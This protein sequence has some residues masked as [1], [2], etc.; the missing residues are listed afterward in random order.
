MVR[1]LSCKGPD[2]SMEVFLPQAVVSDAVSMQKTLRGNVVGQYTLDLTEAG[3]GKF[4]EPVHVR[5]SPD[6][7]SVIVDQYTRKL[8]PTLV[9]LAGGAVNFDN[10]FGTKAKCEPFNE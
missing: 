6:G 7:R 2:A 1:V 5:I 3:K 10:R 9:P 4:M 8:P